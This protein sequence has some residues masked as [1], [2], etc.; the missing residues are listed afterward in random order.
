V[1]KQTAKQRLADLVLGRPLAEF[2]AERRADNR[3]WRL[4]SRDL[5]DATDGAIEITGESLRSWF[6]DEEA[7]AA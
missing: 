2:V 4:I 7:G 5:A 3:A 1:P 6:C